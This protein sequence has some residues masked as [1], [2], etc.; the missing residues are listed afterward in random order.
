M[1]FMHT[2]LPFESGETFTPTQLFMIPSLC[3]NGSYP[4][5]ILIKYKSETRIQRNNLGRVYDSNAKCSAF[6]QAQ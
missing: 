4:N 3:N 1:T 2:R 6:S 5:L